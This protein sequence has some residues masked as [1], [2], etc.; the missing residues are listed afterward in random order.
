MATETEQLES[1]DLTPLDFC[2]RC[3]MQS[4][5]YKRNLGTSDELL[6]RILG[7]AARLKK[8]EYKLRRK[9]RD[10]RVLVSNFIE[11]DGVIF[12]HLL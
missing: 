1:T 7:A 3:W 4:K 11:V 9:T 2:L 12:E 6:D 10:L 5:D 8:G